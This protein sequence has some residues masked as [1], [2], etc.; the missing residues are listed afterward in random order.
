MS[1]SL[2]GKLSVTVF[3]ISIIEMSGM[4]MIAHAA[5]MPLD[6]N[7]L[8]AIDGGSG[9][10]L[11][12]EIYDNI[13]PPT[14]VPIISTLDVAATNPGTPLSCS[15]NGNACTLALQF[16]NRTGEWLVLKDFYT[17]LRIFSINLDGSL[18]SNATTGAGADTSAY[19]DITKFQNLSSACM[20]PTTV[21]CSVAGVGSLNALV[22]SF[23][24]RTRTYVPAT[25]LSTGFNSVQMYLNVGRMAVQ[26]DTSTG[27][28]TG[29]GA[30][31][32][33][34]Q[35]FLGV[36]ISDNNTL[37]AG[38]AIRGKAFVYGF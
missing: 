34:G 3:L 22:F 8:A 25:G 6:E 4:S 35:S 2:C 15:G 23:P 12:F 32:D 14:Q 21:A 20:L 7:D 16:A 10:T 31:K 28:N 17:A 13:T 26:F 18:L 38:A 37:F 11:G 30:A 33:T 29:Y 1:M 19:F 27:D 9:I 24:A 36:V 5:T